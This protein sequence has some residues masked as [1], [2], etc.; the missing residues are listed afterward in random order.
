EILLISDKKSD[1]YIEQHKT[2]TT[3]KGLLEK[4]KHELKNYSESV[5]LKQQKNIVELLSKQYDQI[6][7]ISELARATGAKHLCKLVINIE[8]DALFNIYMNWIQAESKVTK[9][10]LNAWI[11]ELK[12]E[13]EQADDTYIEYQLP[14]EV[15]AKY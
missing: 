7:R 9:S 1:D 15:S 2:C 11:I 3:I 4:K 6:F 12:N 10:T 14:K 13:A 5:E 8:D